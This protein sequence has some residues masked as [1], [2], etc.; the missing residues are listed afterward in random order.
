MTYNV[1]SATLNLYCTVVLQEW[2]LIATLKFLYELDASADG[3]GYWF[4]LWVNKVLLKIW[5]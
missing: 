5:I 1:S 3:F 2:C 4:I